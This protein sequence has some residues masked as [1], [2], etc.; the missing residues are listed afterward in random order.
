[1]KVLR[2]IPIPC[3]CLFVFFSSCSWAEERDESPAESITIAELRD[4]VF[5]L[6]SDELAGRMTGTDGYR[7]AAQY[8]ATQF[9]AAGLEA[10]AIK[11][12]GKQSYLHPVPLIGWAMG[13]GNRL[14]VSVGEEE[15]QLAMV[16]KYVIFEPGP[17]EEGGLPSS[18]PVFVGYGISEVESGWDDY[19]DVDVKGR[20]V[21]ALVG[22][23]P[24]DAM[25]AFPK[26]R[27]RLYRNPLRGSIEKVGAAVKKGAKAIMFAPDM[28]M[29][30]AWGMIRNLSNTT[31]IRL[32]GDES[33]SRLSPIIVVL[34]HPSAAELIFKGQNFNPLSRKGEYRSFEMEGV[35]VG[36]E[37]DITESNLPTDNVVAIVHG[38]D[39]KL[40]EQHI[41]VGAHLDH[42]GEINGM[43]MNGADDN[44]SGSAAI[45]EVAEAVAMNPPRRPVIFILYAAEEVG[46]LGS[47]YF[48]DN[49]PVPI[50]SIMVNINLDMVGREVEQ[51]PDGI[52]SLGSNIICPELKEILLSVNEATIGIPIDFSFEDNDPQN[53]FRRSDHFSFHQKG[54][55]TVVFSS[56]EH[57]D[58]HQPGDDAEKIS[59][60]KLQRTAKLVYELVMSLGNR[61][62]PLCAEQ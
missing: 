8:S 15:H 56:G 44:A 47:R 36:L 52:Y 26:E 39:P 61:D 11:P 23:P 7:I 27:Q 1:M 40:S 16:D 43:V 62:E 58:Y 17:L 49:P 53:Y 29:A 45:L 22:A 10:P 60:N 59:F 41:T 46:L 28:Q 48:A 6:A 24:A 5:F 4:H 2:A 42:L 50:E 9:R 18:A 30:L 25:S 55:P 32:E 19:S 3:M 21:I 51:N 31:S 14:I 38:S 54:I 34:L 20:T 37:T 33:R 13:D 35:L 57:S 12:G